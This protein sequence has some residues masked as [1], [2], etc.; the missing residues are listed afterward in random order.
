MGPGPGT[1]AAMAEPK[2]ERSRVRR[3]PDRASYEMDDVLSILDEGLICH[4]GFVVDGQPYV[5]P[6][7]YARSGDRLFIHGSPLS[8]MLRTAG[9]GVPL[10]LTVTLLDGLVLARSVFNHS[11][12]FRSVMVLGRAT[13]V[14]DEQAKSEGF[15]A[16][17][18]HV[19]QGRWQEARHPTPK[20]LATTKVLSLPLAEASCK[21]RRGG[22]MEPSRD[23]R[24]RIWA[25]QVPISLVAGSAIPEPDLPAG[26]EL[27]DYLSP[28]RRGAA[29]QEGGASPDQAVHKEE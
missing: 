29:D 28:Y 20:E 10:C 13:E 17:V 2:S 1:I 9:E 12:N 3:H 16:L 25:G 14:V 22:S 23:H 19:V 6:T 15:E 26:V 24:L 8:R 7:M 21:I 5:V 27:P 11:M 4:L 18:E